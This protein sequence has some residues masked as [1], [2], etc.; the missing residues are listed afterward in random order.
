MIECPGWLKCSETGV[1]RCL[2]AKKTS[3][4]I[5]HVLQSD[6]SIKMIS[7]ELREPFCQ[8]LSQEQREDLSRR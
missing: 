2:F 5:G 4:E 3:G 6:W 8:M 7:F 1:P